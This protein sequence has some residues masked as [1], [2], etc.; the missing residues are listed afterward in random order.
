MNRRVFS[1]VIGASLALA[2]GAGTVSAA[3]P[4]GTGEPG[5]SCGAELT[6]PAGLV[7]TTNGFATHAGLVYAGSP[8]TPSLANGN[9]LAVSQ[10]DVACFQ[11]S[12]H[13]PS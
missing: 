10:Y 7:S 9:A 12:T 8:G 2:V 4:P 6:G 5:R 11:L 3:N 13:R 1:I